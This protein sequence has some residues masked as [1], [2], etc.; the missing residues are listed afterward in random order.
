MLYDQLIIIH[1]L[2]IRNIQYTVHTGKYSQDKCTALCSVYTVECVVC[3]PLTVS[4]IYTV[5]WQYRERETS[6]RARVCVAVCVRC[7]IGA[8]VFLCVAHVSARGRAGV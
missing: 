6:W 8:W 2:Y 4:F 5:V 7:H 3:T 1:V